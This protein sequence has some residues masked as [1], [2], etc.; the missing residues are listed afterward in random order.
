MAFRSITEYNNARYGG[1]FMLK[2]DGDS[3][4]VVFMYRSIDDVLV[5]DTHYI[6]S[7]DYNGYVHCLGQRICPACER[8]IRVQPK[9][10]I[11]LYVIDTGELLFWDRSVRF[12]QQME[13]DVFSKFSNPSEFIF[14]ITRNGA[15]GDINTRYAIQAVY[16][17]NDEYSYDAILS[18]LDVKL[19]QYYDTVCESWTVAQYQEHLAPK[20]VQQPDVDSMPEYK[21]SPRT[22][23]KNADLPSF[24]TEEE[25]P[26]VL[27]ED[28]VDF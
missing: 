23:S 6:K 3:A 5:A 20:A 8:G 27:N 11:P 14:R 18:N 15:A 21:L 16:R 19:P 26:A 9:I 1:M 17:N 25:F 2:N 24:E 4:D 7:D 22:I 10:F 12:Q 13:N 28:D